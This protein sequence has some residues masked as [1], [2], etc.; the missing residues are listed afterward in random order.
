M[1]F[2]EKTTIEKKWVTKKDMTFGSYRFM[3]L[4]LERVKTNERFSRQEKD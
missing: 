3:V 2:V 1:D 4:K